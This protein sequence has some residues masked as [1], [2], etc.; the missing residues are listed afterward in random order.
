[1]VG[2]CASGGSG[3]QCLILRARRKVPF[4]NARKQAQADED[5]SRTTGEIRIGILVCIITC[6]YNTFES[7]QSRKKSARDM[8]TVSST[9]MLRNN[10]DGLCGG[11]HCHSIKESA[12][13]TYSAQCDQQRTVA[14]IMMPTHMLLIQNLLNYGN[15]GERRCDLSNYLP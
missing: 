6:L 12:L 14:G 8:S 5:K 3:Y 11:R 4:L 2:K 13:F 9:H 10:S 1:M 7:L 15:I